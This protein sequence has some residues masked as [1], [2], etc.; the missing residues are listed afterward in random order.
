MTD[1]PRKALVLFSGGLDSQLALRLLQEQDVYVEAIIFKS[2]FFDVSKA[3]R[4][5]KR[6]RV[7]YRLVDF[8]DDVLE[9]LAA[10]PHG[11]GKAMN[12]CIDCHARMF[13]RAGEAMEASGFDFLAS[14]EVLS[15]R[16]MSQNKQSLYVVARDSDYADL[17]VR[18]LSA[19]LLPPTKPL[20]EGWLDLERLPALSGRNRTPQIALAKRLGVDE[21]PAPAGGCLLT[22]K[23]FCLKLR[24]LLDHEGPD[25]ERTNLWL[26][27]VGRHL[28][29]ADDVKIVVGINRTDN[30]TLRKLARPEDRLLTCAGIPSPTVLAPPEATEEQLAVAGAICARYARTESPLVPVRILERETARLIEVAPKTPEEIDAYR[31]G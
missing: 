19:A 20:R 4:A 5:A 7:R 6:L 21:Y 27:K 18:P 1:S 22:E 2:P 25:A 13:R 11:F 3:I 17:L 31:V 30:E 12:P 8:T 10:P 23:Q 14:G 15:Q 28:R 24:D 26:L 29:L 16:P 9:L